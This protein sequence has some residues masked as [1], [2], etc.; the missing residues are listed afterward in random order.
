MHRSVIQ[1]IA[2]A[3]AI[4]ICAP[5]AHASVRDDAHPSDS[6]RASRATAT[7]TDSAD[8]AGVVNAYHRALAAGDSAAAMTLLAPD[9]IIQESGS[10]ETRSDYAGH[11]LPGDMRFAQALPG[12]RSAQRV[13]V[14]GDVAWSTS[15]SVTKGRYRDR[16]INSAGAEMMVL[17]KDS[18]RWRIRAIHW[19]SRAVKA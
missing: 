12:V 9:A 7:A 3:T 15:T 14:V 17:T 13:V 19:S 6:T 4:T 11:H 1:I 16:D 18:G 5:A 8:V 10:V 2:V